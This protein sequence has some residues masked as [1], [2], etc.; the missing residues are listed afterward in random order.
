MRDPRSTS[1]LLQM[2]DSETGEVACYNAWSFVVGRKA[3]DEGENRGED[4]TE[5]GGEVKDF[6]EEWPE[7]AYVE[8]INSL[9]A[10]G[11]KMMK[12]WTGG[13]DYA[14]TYICLIFVVICIC[15]LLFL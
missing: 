3:G 4:G 10:E 15:P 1:R 9:H 8:A 2:V 7:D 5:A 6:V 11:N 12:K 14:C 13:K